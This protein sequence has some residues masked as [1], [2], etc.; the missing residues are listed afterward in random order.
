LT[1][2]RHGALAFLASALTDQ[3]ALELGDACEQ[4]VDSSRPWARERTKKMAG[5]VL[6]RLID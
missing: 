1:P 3:L 5:A 2:A 6:A 4:R